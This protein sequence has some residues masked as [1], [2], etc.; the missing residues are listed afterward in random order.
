MSIY[1]SGHLKQLKR[2][3]KGFFGE[4][5]RRWGGLL[6]GPKVARPKELGG[7]CIFDVRNL[8]WALRARWMWLQKTDL[9]KPWAQFQIQT[10]KEVQLLFDMAL[11]TEIGDGSNTVLAGQVA[12]W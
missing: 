2:S 9:N 8:S 6:V 12:A 10:C 7:L 5:E 1:R 4:A 3:R 11:V